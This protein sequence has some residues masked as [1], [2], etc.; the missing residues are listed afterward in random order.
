MPHHKHVPPG[1]RRI[2]ADEVT[3]HDVMKEFLPM[4][5]ERDDEETRRRQDE[6]EGEEDANST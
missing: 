4:I 5:Q 2:D 6:E 3:L 1:E